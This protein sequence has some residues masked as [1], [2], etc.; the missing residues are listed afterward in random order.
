MMVTKG[1]NFVNKIKC[2]RRNHNPRVGGSSP[3]PLPPI[4][5][6]VSEMRPARLRLTRSCRPKGRIRFSIRP[7]SRELRPQVIPGR[8]NDGPSAGA[9][10][11]SRRSAGRPIIRWRR[12]PA[13]AIAAAASIGTAVPAKPASSRNQ[14]DR[15]VAVT[16]SAWHKSS[17]RKILG[18]RRM[19]RRCQKETQQQTKLFH[20]SC[21]FSPI[22]TVGDQWPQGIRHAGDD[23]HMCRCDRPATSAKHTV[24]N[25]VRLA[26][27]EY[28]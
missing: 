16:L 15:R 9:D 10:D 6:P 2:D 21:S 23:R 19:R 20:L 3:P 1:G 28:E 18:H 22:R 24:C 27:F 12:I 26:V 25:L 7:T 14:C 11:G 8:A 13:G 4:N 5:H 17:T